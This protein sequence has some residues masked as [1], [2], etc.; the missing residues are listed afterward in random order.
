MPTDH[1]PF[2]SIPSCRHQPAEK[3]A[4]PQRWLVVV[5][6]DAS[7]SLSGDAL[8]A[9]RRRADRLRPFAVKL[10]HDR[11]LIIGLLVDAPCTRC[12]IT[13][14]R[15]RAERAGLNPGMVL[16]GDPDGPRYER[17]WQRLAVRRDQR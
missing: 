10:A 12:A 2:R 7:P 11:H 17:E 16:A 8:A 3:T 13:A 4:A 1:P 9:L 15:T 5:A 6:V 14:A